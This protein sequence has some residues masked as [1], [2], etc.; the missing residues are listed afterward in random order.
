MEEF[1]SDQ[2]SDTEQEFRRSIKK[3][4]KIGLVLALI[5]PLAPVVIYILQTSVPSAMILFIL[6]SFFIIGLTGVIMVVYY[7]SGSS[8]LFYGIDI[9]RKL[10]PPE[11]F[12]QGKFGVL[13]KD[14]VY[15]VAQW[16]SNGLFF[17][18]FSQSERTF[19]QKF[20]VPRL[21]WKWDYNH[22]VGDLKVA[23]KKG[24]YTIPID[25]DTFYTG[26][27]VLYALLLEGTGPVR[28][29]KTFTAEQ[30][31]QIVDNLAAE[32]GGFESSTQSS[33]DDF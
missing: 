13:N 4:M 2:E 14:P 16:G 20:K 29:R 15:G 19:E 24:T 28:I 22:P 21:I 9:L 11:P 1:H 6:V 26:E 17:I 12:I 30:L 8:L 10:A 25:R 7:G 33:T 32:I 23:R 27:G 18:A 3:R 31:Q 5:L